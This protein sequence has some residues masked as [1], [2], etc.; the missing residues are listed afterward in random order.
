M[1]S[2]VRDA[3]MRELDSL[4]HEP[5]EKRVR[6]LVGDHVAIE[7]TRAMLVWE[8]RRIVPSYAVPVEDVRGELLPV[9]E[10]TTRPEDHQGQRLG[11]LSILDPRVPFAVHTADG[12]PV[13]VRV[14]GEV[15]EA[16]GFRVADPDLA[17]HVVLDFGGFD[18]WYDEDE[19]IVSHPR[20]PFHR[21][22]ILHS[23]REVRIE[24]DGELV[25]ETRRP[26][27]LFETGLPMRS[28]LPREDVRVPLVPS[29]RRTRCAYKGEAS[30]W[31]PQVGGRTHDSLAWSYESPLRDAA[32]V[33]GLI[34]FFDE[35]VDVEVDG[36]RRPRPVTPWS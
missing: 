9:P 29:P 17:G 16:V 11:D 13:S 20:D 4:R 24:V 5:T 15:R 6:A 35:R 2:R 25:A 18:A 26:M 31:S 1:S 14:H 27:L 23:S 33:E 3:L 21:I 22:D 32:E 19:R 34:A 12:E 8:P 36:E 7:S 30:Y 10:A 28:Y